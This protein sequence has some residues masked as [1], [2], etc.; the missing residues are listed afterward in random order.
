M[1]AARVI[2]L[3]L[4]PLSLWERVASVASWVRVLQPLEPS[5]TKRFALGPPPSPKGRGFCRDR[6]E[7]EAYNVVLT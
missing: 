2:Y 1:A 6:L 3:S 5:P 4:N 7:I